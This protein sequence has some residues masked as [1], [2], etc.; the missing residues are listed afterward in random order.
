MDQYKKIKIVGRGAHGFVKTNYLTCLRVA[1][2]CR[3]KRDSSLV[4]VKDLYQREMSEEERKASMNEI[5]VL[6]MLRH[7]NIIA[8]YDSFTVDSSIE[9]IINS[10]SLMIVMEYADGRPRELLKILR[11]NTS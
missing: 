4:V 3:R 9:D 7:P 6:S 1:M 2:L 11:R 5:Q 8:Y 10:G